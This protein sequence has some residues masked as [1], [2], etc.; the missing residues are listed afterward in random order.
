MGQGKTGTTALQHAFHAARGALAAHGILYPAMPDGA[1]AH[2]LLLALAEAPERIPDH[3]SEAHGGV[4]QTRRKAAEGFARIGAEVARTRPEVLV[5]SSETLLHGCRGEAKARLSRLLTTLSDDIRPVI[6]VREPAS[7]YLSRAQEKARVAA[8]PLPPGPQRI[9]AAI[10]ETEAAFGVTP[11]VVAFDRAR[12][13]DGSIVADFI[14]RFL[15]DRVAPAEVPGRIENPSLSA[16]AALIL[17]RFRALVAPDSD[18]KRDR[19]SQ[20][21]YRII[22]RLEEN[23]GHQRRPQLRPGLAE[24]I[25]RASV[26]YLWLRDRFDV[27]FP[28]IDYAALDGAPLPSP[29]VGA[30]LEDILEID[31]ARFEALMLEALRLA[32]AG[33]G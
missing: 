15:A 30:P 3:V 10:E 7:L 27:S 24:A 32:L 5:L 1:V 33:T 23:G 22:N 28:E 2:H 26:D 16:E 31:G 12:L 13:A 20:Q 17:S 29:M 14:T 4:E 9:R 8:R 18:W 11:A 21:L 6:Y 19:Q 25:R